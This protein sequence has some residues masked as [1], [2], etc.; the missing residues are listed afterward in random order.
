MLGWETNQ[1]DAALDHKRARPGPAAPV[2]LRAT[3]PGT[4][5]VTARLDRLTPAQR[6]RLGQAQRY[7]HPLTAEQAH[8]LLSNTQDLW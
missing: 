6:Q 4:Y 2:A 5:T 3:G 7:P 1:V 8:M